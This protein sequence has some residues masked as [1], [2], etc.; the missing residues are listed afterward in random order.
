MSETA[1]DEVPYN[2]YSFPESHPDRLATVAHLFGLKPVSP[3]NC[4]V[5]EL[6]AASGGNLAPMAALYPKSQ[7]IGV[8]Y[9]KRQVEQGK[10]L[11]EPLGLKNLE[12][13][14][15][16]ILDVDQSYGKFD[17]IIC[18]GV[19]SWV[20]TEVQDK[21]LAISH[22][23]LSDNGVA[24]ISYN[25]LPGW[26]M[27]GMIRDMMRY[28]AMRFKEPQVRIAQARALLDFIAKTVGTGNENPYS[29]L[30]KVETE[31]LKQSEDWYLYHEHLEEVNAPIY[32]HQFVERAQKAGVRFLGEAMVRQMVP[33]NYPQEVEQVLQR[34][35]PDIVYMEQY[36]DFL[37]NRM[38][39]QTLLCH[40]QHQPQYAL[41]PDRLIGLY[42]A[43]PLKPENKEPDVKT[44]ASETFKM[45]VGTA[46]VQITDPLCKNAAM[47]LVERWPDSIKFE[48][49]CLEA[50]KRL[51]PLMSKPDDI[52]L[53]RDRQLIGRMVL[54]FYMAL[55]DR[56]VELRKTPVPVFP[57]VSDKPTAT[58]LMRAQ[59][60]SGRGATNLKHELGN[61]GEFERQ[62]LR[63]LDGT[64]TKPKLVDLLVELVTTGVLN[65]QKDGQRV[66]DPAEVRKLVAPALDE[67]LNR[68]ASF[69]F[70]I[71]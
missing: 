41:N 66:T 60:Q 6:G 10:Q 35:A 54:Q 11:L 19:F 43:T 39:R 61:L 26:H 49:L 62:I 28:H 36:M 17:Y 4:R 16:S 32:F 53:N 29:A 31:F 46:N 12:L 48:D 65:A 38:F 44:T 56:L 42:V 63:H 70:L 71:A 15:T 9:A 52:T 24:Y 7:F 5:L 59:A 57:K 1:Y 18:H 37:R 51:S 67:A 14:H 25:T 47:I 22:D 33:G 40:P 20:P 55:V 27:R 34:L 30:L 13:R 23:N 2:S 21:I 45:P 50:R 64:Y 68:F 69:S 58:P 8:D 3:E